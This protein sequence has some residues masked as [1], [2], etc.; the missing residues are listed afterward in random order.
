MNIQEL[1]DANSIDTPIPAK[2]HFEDL[3]KSAEMFVNKFGY[4]P[5]CTRLVILNHEREL[6]KKILDKHYPNIKLMISDFYMSDEKEGNP[7]IQCYYVDETPPHNIVISVENYRGGDGIYIQISSALPNNPFS[8]ELSEELINLRERNKKSENKVHFINRTTY[9]GFR[10][11]QYTIDKFPVDINKHYNDSMEEFD[12]SIREWLVKKED[13]NNR[14]VLL[15]GDPGTGKTNYIRN[16]LEYVS[17]MGLKA[18][19][20]P[21]ATSSVLLDPSFISF[22]TEH[23][24]SV[25]IIEDAEEMLL[26]RG[27]SNM[28]NSFVNMMLNLTDGILAGVLNFKV[29]CTF[30]EGEDKID[31]A[32]LRKGRLFKKYKF[33]KLSEDKTKKLYFEL[34]GEEP[35]EKEMTI[36]AIYEREAN[37]IEAKENKGP[38]GFGI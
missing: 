26:S 27:E 28:F 11:D 8:M 2:I 6:F 22:I 23:P 7:D 10:L 9:G 36:S 17:I 32:L 33:E 13:I 24:N 21:P 30:N 19:Y 29:I 5:S 1:K 4:Y 31:D 15:S 20:V 37:G 14:L 16:L 18:I 34:Y 12:S 38:V 3:R 25:L 35:P